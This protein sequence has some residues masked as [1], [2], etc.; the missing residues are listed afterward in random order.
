MNSAGDDCVVFKID[1][2]REFLNNVLVDSRFD[3]RPVD[4]V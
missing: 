1:E 2:D 3:V 4:R